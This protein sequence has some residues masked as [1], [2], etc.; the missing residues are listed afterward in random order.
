MEEDLYHFKKLLNYPNLLHGVTEKKP[1][2]A[3]EFSL[4]LHTH[5]PPQDIISNRYH[6]AK[7]LGAEDGFDFVVANQ[8]HSDHVV[9]IEYPK[10]SGWHTIE[11]AICECDALIT[12]QK[13]VVLTILTADCVPI[14]LYDPT[15]EVIGA[16][17]AGWRGTAQD[18][19]TKTIQKMQHTYGCSPKDII[20]SIAPAIGACCYQI[21]QRVAKHFE[22][23]PKALTPDK[24]PSRYRLNLPYL[25][26][27]ALKELGVKEITL[28]NI[29]TAC[30]EDRFFSYRK[31]QGCQGRFMSMIGMKP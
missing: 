26:A 9:V 4:A 19:T 2:M 31:T 15:K 5:Q 6:L 21:D 17:H 7:V 11:D 24:E 28:S 25:N 1:T 18:I 20:A 10:T 8:T 14:L 16:I 13:G 23:T 12:N 22:A 27:I 29:C 30:E 3:Y